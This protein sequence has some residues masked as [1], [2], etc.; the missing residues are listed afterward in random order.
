MEAKR[1]KNKYEE[2]LEKWS[3]EEENK[4]K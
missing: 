3:N 4:S 2:A 1:N